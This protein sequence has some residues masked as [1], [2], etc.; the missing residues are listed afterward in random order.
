[1]TPDY[2]DVIAQ[3]LREANISDVTRKLPDS[4]RQQE[5][6]MVFPAEPVE[7]TR[8]F[9]LFASRD[10]MANVLVKRESDEQAEAEAWL[11]SQTLARAD[12]RSTDGSYM[13]SSAEI[14]LPRPVAW[15]ES[16]YYVWLVNVTIHE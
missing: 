7:Q 6:V 16:G 9:D 14:G 5:A 11:V 2:C 4:T 13:V 3:R 10:L 15:D 8:Y 12:L 1:M